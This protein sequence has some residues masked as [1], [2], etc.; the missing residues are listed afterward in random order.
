[1][2]VQ[3]SVQTHVNSVTMTHRLPAIWTPSL[4]SFNASHCVGLP[5]RYSKARRR[6][7]SGSVQNP[8][9]HWRFVKGV[10][11]MDTSRRPRSRRSRRSRYWKVFSWWP[12]RHASYAWESTSRAGLGA[13]QLFQLFYLSARPHCFRSF[14]PFMISSALGLPVPTHTSRPYLLPSSVSTSAHCDPMRCQ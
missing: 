2:I 11:Q 5:L 3:N 10:P 12:A 9:F 1:M 6:W 13:I 8:I 14:S 4:C 7:A